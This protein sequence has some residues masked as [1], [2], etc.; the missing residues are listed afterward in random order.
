MPGAIQMSASA[1]VT[2]PIA[3]HAAFR[4][5]RGLLP[6]EPVS[7]RR[8]FAG[9]VFDALVRDLRGFGILGHALL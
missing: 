5:R 1:S 9:G 3:S 4:D 7:R 2:A 6:E 8:R